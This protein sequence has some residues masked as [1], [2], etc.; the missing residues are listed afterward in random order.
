MPGAASVFVSKLFDNFSFID[1]LDTN[2][3]TDTEYPVCVIGF[4][5]KS[6]KREIYINGKRI[7]STGTEIKYQSKRSIK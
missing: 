2:P 4:G 3:F 5:Y 1:F 6:H 7:E